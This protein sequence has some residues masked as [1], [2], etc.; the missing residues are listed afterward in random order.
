[1][2]ACNCASPACQ[3]HGCARAR[4]HVPPPSFM[5]PPP[6]LSPPQQGWQ[7]PSCG[8]V[9]APFMIACLKCTGTTKPDGK[10]A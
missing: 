2:F 7:C 8:A 5:P 4:S 3:A 6:P 10:D 9:Y 1:M